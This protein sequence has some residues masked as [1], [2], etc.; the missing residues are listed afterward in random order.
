MPRIS[1]CVEDALLQ[2][3]DEAAAEAGA[4]LS[5]AIRTAIRAPP[6]PPHDPSGI[7]MTVADPYAAL[8]TADAPR[9]EDSSRPDPLAGFS[10]VGGPSRSPVPRPSTA[11]LAVGVRCAR[12]PTTRAAGT[13]D[14][15][16]I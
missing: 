7:R 6:A 12:T 11:I 2:A 1:V 3:I 16:S 9:Y 10:T 8:H 13:I 5:D 14:R 4:L 15:R